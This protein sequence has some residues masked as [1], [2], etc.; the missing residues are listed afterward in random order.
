[1]RY[2]QW[3]PQQ[4]HR[5]QFSISLDEIIVTPGNL[6]FFKTGL[7]KTVQIRSLQVRRYEYPSNSG[8]QGPGMDPE[9]T[10]LRAWS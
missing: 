5:P 6:G 3:D 10:A 2:T 7:Y 9:T 4:G 8:A 1:M